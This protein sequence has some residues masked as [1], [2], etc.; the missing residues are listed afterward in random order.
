MSEAYSCPKC[1]I[2]TFI[3]HDEPLMLP[4][5]VKSDNGNGIMTDT[6]SGIAVTAIICTTC[7]YVEF[8]AILGDED[9]VL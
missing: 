9:L 6:T 2:K 1:G 7:R 3:K 5:L 8:N 4:R